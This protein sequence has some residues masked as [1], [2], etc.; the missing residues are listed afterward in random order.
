M[1]TNLE[2]AKRLLIDNAAIK[3]IEL[4]GDEYLFEMLKL[5]AIPDEVKEKCNLGD[6]RQ[7]SELLKCDK[8][9]WMYR[10]ERLDGRFVCER[11]G[12]IE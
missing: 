5:A 6:V 1:E 10:G 9:H 3:G 4:K 11:C 7:Q 2:K 12:E 8:H